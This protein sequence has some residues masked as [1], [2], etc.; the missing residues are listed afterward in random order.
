MTSP[1]PAC[2][3]NQRTTVLS[4]NSVMSDVPCTQLRARRRIHELAFWS[5]VSQSRC[6]CALIS[7][8]AHIKD[9]TSA[10]EIARWR[11]VGA[12][13]NY[14]IMYFIR[15]PRART[16]IPVCDHC[17]KHHIWSLVGYQTLNWCALLHGSEVKVLNMISYE[18]KYC[19]FKSCSE[20]LQIS[21]RLQFTK[22]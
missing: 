7:V 18:M 22:K 15:A 1:P 14:Q 19:S 21:P 2:C 10:K 5:F 13:K 20:S 16:F 8:H 11:W 17:K 4:Q 3:A 6:C 12:V 9:S